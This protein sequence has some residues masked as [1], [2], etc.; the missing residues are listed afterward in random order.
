MSDL[1]PVSIHIPSADVHHYIE[2][3]ISE[4]SR[5]AYKNDFQHFINWG[6][7]IPCTPEHLVLYLTSHAEIL[8]I[9]TLQR[10]LVAI[11][12]AHALAG[13]PLPTKSELVRLTMQGIKRLHGKPQAQV[14][15]I[16]KED[17]VVML[18]HIPDTI[19]GKRDR[20][21]LLLGFC[22]AFRR[23]ELVALK[24][25]DL[26][27]TTQ[28]LIVTLPRSKVDQT[29]QGRKIGIPMGRGKI[30][31]VQAVQDWLVH[32]SA[33]NGSLFK[34]ISKGGV[35]SVDAL[36]DRA[37][38]NIIKAYVV[39]IGLDPA[40]YSGHSLR[41]GLASSAA[42]HGYSSWEIRRQTGHASDA[43]LQRYIRLG[44]LFLRNA[45][46]IF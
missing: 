37:V 35:L 13:Y 16:M 42:E 28:G 36:S 1:I 27:F 20:A 14:S 9:A 46:G 44:S 4:N 8:S 30:C 18:S 40:R 29:G 32:L 3:S 11:A 12:K 26:E 6:G 22:G 5:K 10:R 23:S 31:P 15:P 39:K 7:C 25:T 24:C 45:A 19:K 41:A 43:M 17:L 33:N 2:N 38:A 34:A 21:L